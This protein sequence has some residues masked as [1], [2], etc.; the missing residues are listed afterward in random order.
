MHR[1]RAL[2]VALLLLC[3]MVALWLLRENGP[4]SS[5]LP[6]CL[7]HQ[8]TGLHCPGC[9]M[10]RATHAALHGDLAGAFRHNVLG[11]IL[12]PLAMLG[13]VLE[14]LAW[15]KTSRAGWRLVPPRGLA[16]LLGLAVISFWL[17]RNL[18]WWPFNLLAPPG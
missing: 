3:G 5:L 10:T 15:T 17:L 13:I 11:M 8:L 1:N 16:W 2:I 18:P 14:L 9:G 4:G 7:F 6:P 12:L